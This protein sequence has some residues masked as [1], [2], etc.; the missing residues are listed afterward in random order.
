MTVKKETFSF[1]AAISDSIFNSLASKS[2]I[3]FYPV[4]IF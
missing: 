1:I 2:I 3:F 4:V